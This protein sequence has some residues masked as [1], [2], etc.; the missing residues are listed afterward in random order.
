M[1]EI[2]KQ[3]IFHQAVLLKIKLSNAMRT[4]FKYTNWYTLNVC[5]YMIQWLNDI[6]FLRPKDMF[7]FKVWYKLNLLSLISE[8]SN[9]YL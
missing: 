1:N 4:Y 8:N 9:F 5:Y 6:I 3:S 2:N 7:L